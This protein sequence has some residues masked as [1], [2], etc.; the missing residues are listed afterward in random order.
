EAGDE[1]ASAWIERVA[2]ASPVEARAL[3]ALLRVRQGRTGEAVP[4]LEASLLAY[5]EDPWPDPGLMR[6]VVQAAGDAAAANAGH[7]ARL[8]PALRAPFVLRAFEEERLVAL[9]QAF[10]RLGPVPECAASIAALEPFV[11][12]VRD[13]LELRARCYQAAADP[14]A[15]SARAD[16]GVFLSR[17]PMRFSDGLLP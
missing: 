14:R 6:R 5:R 15:G 10:S 2:M 11:P 13:W 16:L 3:G 8:L 1:R 7:A 4:E 12:W 9:A 17:E